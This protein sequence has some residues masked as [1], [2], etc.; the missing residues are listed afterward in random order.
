MLG[1]LCNGVLH[2]IFH[3]NTSDRH[4]PKKPKDG[5]DETYGMIITMVYRSSLVNLSLFVG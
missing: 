2:Q 4:V 1:F 3:T 5:S